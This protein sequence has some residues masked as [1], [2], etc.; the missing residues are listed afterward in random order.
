MFFFSY[1]TILANPLI[2]NSVFLEE[3][4][5]YF[6]SSLYIFKQLN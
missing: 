3:S 2:Y 4:D 5:D 1:G 6:I